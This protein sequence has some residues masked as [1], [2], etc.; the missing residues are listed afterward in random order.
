VQPVDWWW[1]RKFPR[2]TV[3]LLPAAPSGTIAF[4]L[5]SDIAVITLSGPPINLVNY[6]LWVQGNPNWLATVIGNFGTVAALDRTW[7]YPSTSTGTFTLAKL[8]YAMPAD[9]LHFVTP[10]LLID[11]NPPIS[12]VDETAL[13]Q[14]FPLSQLQRGFPQL[15]CLSSYRAE[16]DTYMLRVS[17]YADAITDA[18]FDYVAQ[19]T[20][21]ATG[22]ES[23][24]MPL[25][26]RR[27][28]SFGAAYLILLDKTDSNAGVRYKQF[29]SGWEAMAD[30]HTKQ[31]GRGSTT[32]GRIIPRGTTQAP[33]LL[34]TTSGMIIG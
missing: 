20:G 28:L 29:V 3:R 24:P 10:L 2:G 4:T 34:R 5:G 9:F 23:P 33:R 17:H 11:G 15:A 14:M 8:H 7:P 6:T 18:E 13:E 21:F 16:S 22:A 27:I 19:P 1:A 32:F 31:V 25:V 30:E 12:V 26:H